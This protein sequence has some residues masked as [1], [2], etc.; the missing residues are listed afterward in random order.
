MFAQPGGRVP[1]ATFTLLPEYHQLEKPIKVQVQPSFTAGW[2]MGYLI[3]WSPSRIFLFNNG[4]AF[5][6]DW[7]DIRGIAV[8]PE[9]FPAFYRADVAAQIFLVTT[10]TIRTWIKAGKLD[11]FKRNDRWLVTTESVKAL[12]KEKNG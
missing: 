4:E 9:D 3:K 10:P 5:D 8:I 2:R 7:L 11:G 1:V 12:L 6:W